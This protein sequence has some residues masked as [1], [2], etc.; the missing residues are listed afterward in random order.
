[1]K[2][3]MEVSVGNLIAIVALV[4]SLSA[5]YAHTQSRITAIETTVKCLPSLIKKLEN[6]AIQLENHKVRLENREC[7]TSANQ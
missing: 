5:G 1:M 4:L 7:T 2:L 6:I 3:N